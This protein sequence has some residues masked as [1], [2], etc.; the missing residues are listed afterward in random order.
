MVDFLEKLESLGRGA[1]VAGL[2]WL[3]GKDLES[4]QEAWKILGFLIL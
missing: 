3:M 4:A 2:K 1:G